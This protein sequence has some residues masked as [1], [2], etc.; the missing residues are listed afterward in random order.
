MTANPAGYDV[1]RFFGDDQIRLAI[2][3]DYDET[4]ISQI[5]GLPWQDTKREWDPDYKFRSGREG[6]WTIIATRTSLQTVRE[7]TRL[8]L[9]TRSE[10]PLAED[11][12]ETTN[13]ELSRSCPRCEKSGV[14]STDSLESVF[15]RRGDALQAVIDHPDATHGCYHCHALIKSR[16]LQLHEVM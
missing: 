15:V 4:L 9:P 2:G 13:E 7:Q 10:I 11:L 6:A 16:P 5:K 3:F 14:M 12:I 1:E 8:Q